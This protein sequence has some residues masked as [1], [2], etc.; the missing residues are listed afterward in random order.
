MCYTAQPTMRRTV[1]PTALRAA[2]V[3]LAAGLV[4]TYGLA[5]YD[6]IANEEVGGGL[7]A[8]PQSVIYWAESVL[9]YWWLPLLLLALVSAGVASMWAAI[10][11][12]AS[13]RS[14][15]AV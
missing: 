9:P 3:G 6:L 14:R 4:V 11:G 8:I 2:I 5:W 7:G 1:G 15:G 12:R 10:S 13:A